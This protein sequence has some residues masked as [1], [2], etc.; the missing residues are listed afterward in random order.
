MCGIEKVWLKAA[1]EVRQDVPP[2]NEADRALIIFIKNPILGKIKT[3]LAATLGDHAALDAYGEMTAHV[4]TV[5][6]GV[7]CHRAV[8]YS[9]F[10]DNQDKWSSPAFAKYLQV[11]TGLGERMLAAFQAMFAEG[12]QKVAIVGSDFLDLQAQ[13][14]EQAF[15]ALSFHDFVIGP[16]DDGGYYLLGMKVLEPSVFLNKRWST[17]SVFMSTMDDI[18]DAG[19]LVFVLPEISDIDDAAA[20]DA[21][22]ARR[23]KRSGK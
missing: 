6:S 13:H 16:T 3:R 2:R 19:K 18:R 4:R 23:E 12:F 17:S 22:R 9:D 14:L 1:G 8:F 20:W 5:A 10:I 21:A 7:E 11:P 15:R